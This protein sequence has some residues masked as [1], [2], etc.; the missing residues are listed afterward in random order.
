MKNTK[1]SHESD[2]DDDI[3]ELDIQIENEDSEEMISVED[4]EN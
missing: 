1:N 4:T 2:N 3:I